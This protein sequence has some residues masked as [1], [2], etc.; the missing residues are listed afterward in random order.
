MNATTSCTYAFTMEAGNLDNYPV[1]SSAMC[2]T[3]MPAFPTT[4]PYTGPGYGDWIFVMGLVVGLL[5]ISAAFLIFGPLRG[6]K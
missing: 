1:V 3:T 4:T 5:S 2:S 6:V